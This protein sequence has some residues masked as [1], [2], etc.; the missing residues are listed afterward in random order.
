MF[1][2]ESLKTTTANQNSKRGPHLQNNTVLFRS[3]DHASKTL[4]DLWLCVFLHGWFKATNTNFFFSFHLQIHI[5]TAIS[6]FCLISSY[7]RMTTLDLVFILFIS[8]RLKRE[9][10]TPSGPYGRPAVSFFRWYIFRCHC[11][12]V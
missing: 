2:K 9:I 5:S 12:R 8:F 10:L 7:Y 4:T 1:I 11:L 3:K 6:L